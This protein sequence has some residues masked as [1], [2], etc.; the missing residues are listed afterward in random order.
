MRKAVFFIFIVLFLYHACKNTSSD[1]HQTKP[2]ESYPSFTEDGAWCW[3]SDPRAVYFEGKYKRTYCGWIDS[4]ANVIIGYYDHE[5][6]NLETDTIH[7][8]LEID[9]HDNPSLFFESDGT[10]QVYY[11]RHSKEDG[12][13]VTRSLQPENIHDWSQTRLLAL[14]DTLSGPEFSKTYTYTNIT[15]LK[16]ESDRLFLFWRGL[17]FKPNVS[18]SDDNGNRWSTGKILILP[19]RIYK[20]RRPYMKVTSDGEQTIHIA[21]T[22]GHP[23]KESANSI[24]YVAYK[25]GQFLKADGEK[26][27]SWDDL[28]LD[29]GSCDKVYDASKSR[30]RA[31]IWDITHNK[32]GSPVLVYAR[33]RD[34]SNHMYYYAT[35]ENGNWIN[36]ELVN[37][38]GWFP[39]TPDGAI[40]TETYYSGGIVLDHQDPSRVFLSRE[41][42]GV[43]E[44]EQWKTN[45]NGKDWDITPVTENSVNDNV[46]PFVVRNYPNSE[47]PVVLWMNLRKY[48]HYTD[49]D[50][51]IKCNLNELIR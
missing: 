16:N 29:P 50:A 25:N 45:N 33:F 38:G 51:S 14:N 20:N 21:F 11:T 49:Y 40:E 22:D 43:F 30:E 36:Y 39:H 28:P 8:A 18:I 10:I 23:N 7:R 35:Y 42:N 19:E 5:K 4:K 12:I 9:D 37:S 13:Y 44:I 1:V 34:E 32:T 6:R 31:W 3:F 15:Q 48:I 2:G 26:I 27:L 47:S 24:Y 46:R 17:D 41:K